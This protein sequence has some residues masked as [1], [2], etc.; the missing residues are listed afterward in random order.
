M[1]VILRSRL[2]M[3]LALAALLLAASAM[4]ANAETASTTPDPLVQV[5]VQK[6]VLSADEAK[7]ITGTAE[8]QRDQ[9]VELLKQKGVI[10]SAEYDAVLAARVDAGFEAP[11][12]QAF[13][14][15]TQPPGT[16]V[17]PAT[18]NAQA[19]QAVRP[20]ESNQPLALRYKGLTLTPGGF[21]SADFYVRSRNEN[22]D[23]TSN[24]NSTPFG[25]VTNSHLTEFHATAKASRI[26]LLAEGQA[27]R[28]KL[29]GYFEGD[30]MSAAPTSN[31]VETNAWP[32][33]VRQAWGQSEFANG[34]TL[35]GG[36]FWTLLN[37]DRKGIALR[38]EFIP[39]TIEASYV[40]GYTYV[41]QTAI[42]FTKN[43]NNRIWAAFEVA[44]PETTYATS[45]TPSFIMGLNTSANVTSPF[46]NLLPNLAAV[47]PLPAA[48][49]T[50]S[51]YQC[52]PAPGAYSNGVSTNLA[53]DLIAKVAF[54]PG[55]GHYEIK[56]L[57]RFFRDRLVPTSTANLVNSSAATTNVTE[58]GGIGWGM[59]LPVV[60]KKVDVIF[61][62][63]VGAGIGRYGAAVN[64]DVTIRPSDG[65]LIPLKQLHTLA[66]VEWHAKPKLDVYLYG[67]DEYI[68]RANYTSP[69]GG[70]AGYGSP[71]VNTRNCNVELL[72]SPA[73]GGVTGSGVV[74]PAGTA[75]AA[76]GAQNKNLWE[77]TAGFWYRLY[78][79]SFG[80]FQYGMQYEY[81]YRTTYPG[82]GGAPKGMD[83]IAFSSL[84]FYLP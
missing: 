57:G 55:W 14:A 2:A 72:T 43:F 79:G 74:V 41:R 46:T 65:A 61:E 13:A 78:Q 8:Q 44:N 75:V 66:G 12:S 34:M 33:R 16:K 3:A 15:N 28:T 30:F 71:L 51:G 38:S 9:L 84:R 58:G 60:S 76:C 70:A 82:I 37:T 20:P 31:Q 4:I 11:A 5:L 54:E 52:N 18:Y 59:I 80:T 63:M 40:I 7:S 49:A 10:S 67:G 50:T 68:R 62:G 39:N 27:G 77:A 32:F 48:T 53:P 35:S 69:T 23:S 42:R 64:P 26:S 56:I 17:V 25:G 19:A 73:T 22:S 81:L 83:S 47:C 24:F 6:G 45:F 1:T 21:A 36:Q 29:S